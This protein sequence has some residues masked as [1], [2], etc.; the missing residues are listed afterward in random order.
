MV[1]FFIPWQEIRITK[2]R[3]PHW[4]QP[5]V[6]YFVTWRLADALPSE[7]IH[8]W[9]EEFWEWLTR[10]P[11]PWSAEQEVEYQVRFGDRFEAWLDAGHGSCALRERGVNG[12]MGDALMFHDGDR[13][14]QHAWIVM[15]NHVHALF[16]IAEGW[17]LEQILHTWKSFTAHHLGLRWQR[18]YH[19][20]MIRSPAH[21]QHCRGYARENPISARLPDG[22]F[23]WFERNE[24]E[25][26]EY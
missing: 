21:F 23:R 6:T 19:D 24:S 13:Y 11:K 14:L 16:T 15:P 8:R 12:K 2:N 22:S 20:R 9:K 4:Q 7:L 17:A 5:G 18:G 26:V 10:N 25:A 1:K 3:L